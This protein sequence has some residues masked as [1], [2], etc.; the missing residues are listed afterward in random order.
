VKILLSAFQ[1]YPGHGSEPATG[2]QWASTLPEFGHEVT[3]LTSSWNR[4]RIEAAGPHGA[5]F[6]YVDL[7]LRKAT[8]LPAPVLSYDYY[9][10]W[11]DAALRCAQALPGH[12]DVIHHVTWGGLHLGSQLWRL[13]VPMIYGPIGG[14]QTA[15]GAYWRYFGREWP[16]ELARTAATGSL[17]RLNVRSRETIR[18]AD[19]TLVCNSDTE[20]A[21]RRLGAQDV[22]FMLADGMPTEWLGEQRSRP[23][24]LPVVFWVGRLLPRKA[25]VL[26]I[27]AFAELRKIMPA[28]LVMA[29]DGPLREQVRSAVQRLGIDQDVQ[30]LG[31]VPLAD[32]KPLYDAASVLLFTTLR[33]S[34]GA[35][36]LEAMGRGLPAVALD[37][38]GI[39]DADVGSAAVK[40]PLPARSRDL[41]ARMGAALAE[42]LSDSRW[43][44]RSVAAINWAAGWVWPAKVANAIKIY[45][46]IARP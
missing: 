42:I 11:Q 2:W 43:E 28:R 36:I 19:V 4:P 21:A 39:A 33:E 46:E 40:V 8:W 18:N 31:Q 3:V 17:L 14:G 37:H 23:D 20:A 35:P 30:L 10:R 41:P 5:E 15:P 25:P 26:A 12:Y 16:S 24:G 38:H 29:G 6:C 7:P 45:H 1:C 22:R 32:V 9:L 13:P 27:E 44:A 34:I